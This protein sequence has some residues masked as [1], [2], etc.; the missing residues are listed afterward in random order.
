[1][2]SRNSKRPLA[3][4]IPVRRQTKLIIAA[5]LFGL[6]LIFFLLLNSSLGV[7]RDETITDRNRPQI[8][9]EHDDR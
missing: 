7:D 1:M 5:A 6:I 4:T 2:F 3:Y 9:G 8:V